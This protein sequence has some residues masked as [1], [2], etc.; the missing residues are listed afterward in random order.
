[1]KVPKISFVLSLLWI[2]VA[3]VSAQVE[4]RFYPEGD[5][6]SG[7][8][9]GNLPQ[10]RSVVEVKKMEAFDASAL[11]LEDSIIQADHN[12]DVPFRF[13]KDFSVNYSL[14]NGVWEYVGEDRIWSLSFRSDNAYS[15]NFIFDDFYLPQ[16]A[17]LYI[18]N[19]DRTMR[20]GPVTA[21][22]N[23]E[24]GRFLTDLVAGDNVTLYLYEP[25]DKIGQSTL[26]V[27]KVVHAYRDLYASASTELNCYN[28]VSCYS[29]YDTES[30]AVAVILR[31]DGSSLCTGSMIM[32]AN[33]SFDPYF[34]TAFHCL[35]NDKNG[36]LSSGERNGV[37]NWMFK[38]NYKQP[39]TGSNIVNGI[40]YNGSSFKSALFDS[41]FA[42]LELNQAPS[43][44]SWL[45]WDRRNV[46]ATSGALI[47]H[48]AGDYMKISFENDPVSLYTGDLH[49]G[50]GNLTTP[51][52]THWFVDLD[53]GA[54]ERGSSGSPFLN[55]EKRV[56][57][58]LHGGKIFCPPDA[59]SYMGAF[60]YSWNHSTSSS[61]QLKCWLDPTNTGAETTNTRLYPSIQGDKILCGT[62]NYTLNNAPAGTITWRVTGD[63]AIVS[64]QG[65]NRVTIKTALGDWSG[66]GKIIA[67]TA[68]GLSVSYDVYATSP[69]VERISGNQ[70]VSLNQY[71]TYTAEP[72]FTDIYYSLDYEWSVTPSAEVEPFYSD[73][74]SCNI[75]FTSPGTYTVQCRS[76]TSCGYQP[77]GATTFTVTTSGAR[78]AISQKERQLTIA[79]PED[80]QG[81]QPTA[82]YNIYELTSGKL[83]K[84]G[85][86]YSTTTVDLRNSKPGIYLVKIKDST[87]KIVLQ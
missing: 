56:V 44:A 47:H 61:E 40:T 29:A 59:E 78:Y 11:L 70:L 17:E 66:R 63:L 81:E 75:R 18:V 19:E 21:L 24:N 53:N 71:Y 69:T 57:G 38:F 27:S 83:E 20:Y 82:T 39:C 87:Y 76:K 28:N 23:P 15:L 14:N 51:P 7:T 16:G 52:N 64:G 80:L 32:T 50:S 3:M 72:F 74:R 1:M 42:L 45:G 77:G 58:Q 84:T 6:L 68:A 55:Q 43:H 33:E 25:G 9:L 62:K 54:M 73:P 4:T 65:S 37:G 36:T 10:R 86:V 31:S 22:Q 13:G 5:A 26:T 60:Y 67:T 85:N 49:W 35:D 2:G 46:A 41:D 12:G 79:P 34:L 8:R 30:K 48:P